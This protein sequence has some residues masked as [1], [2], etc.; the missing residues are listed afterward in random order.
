MNKDIFLYLKPNLESL[1][2]FT[3]NKKTKN[4][5]STSNDINTYSNTR[6]NFTKRNWSPP[7]LKEDFKGYFEFDK[8]SLIIQNKYTM[9]FSNEGIFNFFS[10]EFLDSFFKNFKKNYQIIYIRPK[11][12][13]SNYY[14]DKNEIK[15]FKDYELIKESHP[16]VKTIYDFL[17]D[18]KDFNIL[19]FKLHATS[20][21]H[22]S[23]SGGNACL[24][25]YFGGELIIF[26]SPNGEGSGRGIW[27]DDSWLKHLSGSKIKGFN[28]Y[29]DIINYTNKKW[30]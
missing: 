24:A 1:Y 3:K 16:D 19:Q 10:L 21:K 11:P 9:E 23:V 8:P 18:E 25:A 2:Y 12:G 29:N 17:N 28:N 6:P 5:F 14:E 15:P 20:D 26:D 7:L 13:Q 30:K 22:L 27:K 4:I